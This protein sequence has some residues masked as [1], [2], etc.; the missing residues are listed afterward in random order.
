MTKEEA[1][2]YLILPVSTSTVMSNETAKRYEAY[3]MAVEAL[4]QEPMIHAHWSRTP[5][6]EDYQSDI[7]CSNCKYDFTVDNICIEDYLRCPHCGAVMDE[8]VKDEA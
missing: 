1:I 2:K 4:R 7:E 5:S 3:K 6:L 8:V